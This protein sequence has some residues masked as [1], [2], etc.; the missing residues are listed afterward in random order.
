MITRENF[1]A[2]LEFKDVL[3]AKVDEILSLKCRLESDKC[4][5]Y[6]GYIEKIDFEAGLVEVKTIE[7]SR[8]SCCRDENHYYN[9]PISYLFDTEWTTIVKEE[10]DRKRAEIE[11]KKQEEAEQQR[12]ERDERERKE[13]ERLQAKFER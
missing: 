3:E 7:E 12:K 1:D 9:F 2:Y 6:V 10:V 4:R 11:R 5:G 8:C 13:Y